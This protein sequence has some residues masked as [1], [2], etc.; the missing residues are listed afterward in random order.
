MQNLENRDILRKKVENG[1]IPIEINPEKQNRHILGTKEYK[2]G[3]SYFTVSSSQL[4]DIVKQKYATGKVYIT[5]D[6]KQ[7]RENIFLASNIGVIVNNE[8]GEHRTN[9]IKI[10]YSRTGVHVVPYRKR[11]DYE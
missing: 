3:R 1:E 10:H 6:G 4:Q 8:T 5:N 7:I 2:A 11:K 9:G